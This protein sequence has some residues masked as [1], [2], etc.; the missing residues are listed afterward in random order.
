MPRSLD[1]EIAADQLQ[2]DFLA[3]V[4]D[5]EID[6]AEAA[7]P[8]AALDG[9]AVQGA[10]AAGVDEPPR[11]GRRRAGRPWGLSLCR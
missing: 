1:V 9:I 5:G 2:G 8:D 6:F 11:P 10:V 3:G 7:V 4:A